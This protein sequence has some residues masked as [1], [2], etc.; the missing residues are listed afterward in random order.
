MYNLTKFLSKFSPHNDISAIGYLVAYRAFEIFWNK[1]GT[2]L[3][4]L[5]LSVFMER[6]KTAAEY[7]AQKY[8]LTAKQ[9]LFDYSEIQDFIPKMQTRSSSKDHVSNDSY[10]PNLSL[11]SSL[12]DV[13][14]SGD[15]DS[16]FVINQ[17]SK[18]DYI[19]IFE[20]QLNSER[21]GFMKVENFTRDPTLPPV[22]EFIKKWRWEEQIAAQL[23]QR[24]KHVQDSI[25]KSSS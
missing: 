2:E 12:R 5:E 23:R 15:Y 3:D 7:A 11:V 25:G 21:G 13:A 16:P 18:T 14:F 1:Y 24:A 9:L 22:E 19:Q 17:R 4:L 20:E 6:C 8:D 10:D